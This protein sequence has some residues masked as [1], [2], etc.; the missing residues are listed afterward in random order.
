MKSSLMMSLENHES[1]KEMWDY[2]KGRDMFRTVVLFS[3]LSCK[4]FMIFAK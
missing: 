3:L 1:A 4:D 2:L